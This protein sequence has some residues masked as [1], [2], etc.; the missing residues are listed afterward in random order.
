[1]SRDRVL[2][3]VWARL[4]DLSPKT[5]NRYVMPFSTGRLIV[6]PVSLSTVMADYDIIDSH[7]HVFPDL[8][9]AASFSRGVGRQ[10]PHAGDLTDAR[11]MMTEHHV[12]RVMLLPLLPARHD[13]EIRTNRGET[14]DHIKAEIA[15]SWTEYNCWASDT[16]AAEPHRFSAAVAVDPVLLGEEWARTEI[17]R[18]ASTGIRAIKIMPAWI[19][20]P[21]DDPRM[22]VVWELASRFDLPVI[23][24]S[25]LTKDSDISHPDRF[26]PVVA[27]YPRVMVVL[28][29]MGLGAEDRTINL[30]AR[31]PNVFVDTSAWFEV[32]PNPRSWLNLQRG[33]TPPTRNDAADLIRN[34]G[35]DRVLFG[36]N[37]A[38][39]DVATPHEWLHSLPLSESERVQIFSKNYSRVFSQH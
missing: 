11:T 33:G 39:R 12:R 34:I 37:Y 8:T 7:T 18:G 19:G 30:A 25:G 21:P 17:E 3:L 14:P 15:A 35:I 28:A 26:E 6:T 2:V 13:F 29:H 16:A 31:F 9:A 5:F 10:I 27:A 22:G 32:A 1:M 36:T 4:F 20:C 38:I 24:Q 23:S